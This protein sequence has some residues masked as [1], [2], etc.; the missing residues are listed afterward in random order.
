M[1]NI[2]I[3]IAARE[4]S[5]GI[6]SKNLLKING[7]TLI[8]RTIRLA[9]ESSLTEH[10]AV[11]TDS[12]EIKKI[13]ED[14]G[15]SCWFKRSKTLS[16]DNVAKVEVIRDTLDK[17]EQYFNKSF[18]IVIDLDVTAPLTSI[19][20]VKGALDLFKKNKYQFVTTG[21]EARKNPYFNMI[22]VSKN[23]LDI[24]NKLNKPFTSRQKAPKVFE[25]NGA[26]YVYSRKFLKDRMEMFSED[27]GLFLMP[28]ERSCDIDTIEDLEYVKF[29]LSREQNKNIAVIGGNGLIGSSVVNKLKEN[30]RIF[31]IDIKNNSN[32]KFSNN[33]HNYKGD[34]LK[35]KSIEKIFEDIEKE[36]GAINVVINCTHFKRKSWGKNLS[37][38]TKDDIN[39]SMD[40]LLT[41]V[42]L[43]SN[44]AIKYFIKNNGGN[45]INLSSIQGIQAPKF[46]HYQNTN[47]SSPIEYS[48]AK[49]S[50]ISMTK[51][52][53]KFYK[54]NNIRINCV[55]PGGILDGQP[56]EFINNYRMSTSNIGLL[57]PSDISSTI[58]WLVSENSRAIN[59]QN[60]VVDDGW[61]L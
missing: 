41:S 17:A 45:L 57:D 11:S 12:D 9:K 39:E 46:W 18:E 55:S 42:F 14:K 61:S 16:G 47:M 25:L 34:V 15:V 52:L 4:G 19:E 6:P 60:I 31:N 48:M 1:N 10:I 50:I 13:S 21:C 7:E 32:Y 8:E 59:G 24:I 40:Q 38:L 22:H 30:Y 26:V 53:A 27:Q 54:N 43:L 20:D 5:K 49:T 28:Q 44:L 2:L 3:T 37:K 51:Y 33:I 29:K 58:E 23:R 56:E 36:H 35:I